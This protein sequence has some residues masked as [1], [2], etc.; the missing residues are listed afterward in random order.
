MRIWKI[1]V[2]ALLAAVLLLTAVAPAI[3]APDTLKDKVAVQIQNKTGSSVVIKLT[4]P[5]TV[6]LTLNTG[7]NKTELASGRYQYSYTACGGTQTGTFKVKAGATL[8]LPKCKTG[9]GGAGEGKQKIT[10]NTGGTLTIILS[11]PKNYTLYVATGKSQ[12][13][14][15]KGKYNYTIYGCGGAALTGSRK[16]PGGGNWMF[17][18]Y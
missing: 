4:G 1:T 6:Y 17:W 15:V 7:K 3:A 10:N 2:T 9:G 11:G 12:I 18:C 14:I 16:L 13:S 8:V 5:A